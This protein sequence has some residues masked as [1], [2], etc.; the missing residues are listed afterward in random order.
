MKDGIAFAGFKMRAAE[1]LQ[2]RVC[3]SFAICVVSAIGR[4]SN[5]IAGIAK[6]DDL[7]APIRKQPG[8][9]HNAAGDLIQPVHFIAFVVQKGTGAQAGLCGFWGTA[10]QGGKGGGNRAGIRNCDVHRRVLRARV[11]V[12]LVNECNMH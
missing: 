8:Q 3:Q 2:A 4:K 1:R 7:A 9:P 12:T 6:G 10:G 11:G 5:D